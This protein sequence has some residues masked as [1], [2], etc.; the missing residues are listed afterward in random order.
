M[1]NEKIEKYSRQLDIVDVE[2][3]SLPI[4]VIG[5]GGI[6]SWTA[7]MLAKMGC[8][9]VTIYDFDEVEYHNCAS[10]YFEERQIGMLK[11][12][13]LVSNV[14]AQTGVGLNIG[15]VE[16]EKNISEGVVIIAVDSIEMRW[17]LNDFYKDKDLFII[18]ARMGGLQAEVYCVMS[19]AYE[20]TLVQPEDVQREVCTAK[21]ISFNC[22]LIGS[23]I[24]N[25]I[26]LYVNGNMDLSEFRER[27]F[28]FDPVL[29]IRPK[30]I[31]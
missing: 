27:T 12:E 25:Y 28:M 22:A 20:S 15:D 17:K 31:D 7:L 3:L 2:K 9:N 11:T 24:A 30:P 13:A 14:Y 10:Q 8:S 1:Q 5:C 23:L 18:D 29:M 26:R 19:M 6:G 16:E 4:H 21:A